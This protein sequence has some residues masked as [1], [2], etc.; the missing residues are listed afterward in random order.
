M[1]KEEVLD[2]IRDKL[3]VSVETDNSGSGATVRVKLYLDDEEIYSD[4]DTIYFPS[5]DN[6]DY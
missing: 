2:L 5:R 3:R 4:S 6:S 1:T